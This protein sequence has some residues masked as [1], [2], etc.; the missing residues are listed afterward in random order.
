LF[1]WCSFFTMCSLHKIRKE[2]MTPKQIMIY[3]CLCNFSSLPSLIGQGGPFHSASPFPAHTQYC[4]S[5][6]SPCNLDG[7]SPRTKKPFQH[8]IVVVGEHVGILWLLSLWTKCANTVSNAYS[9]QIMGLQDEYVW[10]LQI[11]S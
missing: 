9:S 6:V 2:R 11:T 5:R 1:P 10:I 4:T 7:R 3:L 8:L